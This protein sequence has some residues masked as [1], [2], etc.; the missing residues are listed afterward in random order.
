[1]VRNRQRKSSKGLFL[2]DDMK[3]AVEMVMNGSSVRRAAELKNVSYV[4]L[5]RY[6]KKRKECDEDGKENMKYAPNYTVRRVF[7]LEQEET[8]K[9]YL[10]MCSKIF[11]GLPVEDCRRVAYEMAVINKIACPISWGLKKIA[12]IDW[13]YGF[14]KRHPQLSQRTPEAC[15]LSRATSFTKANV[16]VFFNNLEILYQQ[17]PEFGDGTRVFNLDETATSTV[18][19]PQRI[20]AEK[21][22]KQVCK[23]T[24][25]EKGTN[26]TTVAI[27]SASG[28]TI[29][30][31]MIFPRVHFKDYMIQ[32]AP[33]GTLG[34]ATPSGWM[35]SELFVE[36]IKH[37]IRHTCSSGENPT[38]L[39]YDNVESHLSLEAVMLCKENGVSVLTLPPHSSN[40]M[41]PL[42]VA[43]FGP[44]K[45]YYNAALDSW[46]M[47]NPGKTASIYN[48][49]SFVNTAHQKSMTPSNII[50]GFKKSGIHP[51]DRDIFTEADFLCNYVTDRPTPTVVDDQPAKTNGYAVPSDLLNGSFPQVEEGAASLEEGADSLEGAA[52]NHTAIGVLDPG[53]G[54]SHAFQSPEDFRGYPK[55]GERKT[56][57]KQRKKGKSIIATSTPEMKAIAEKKNKLIPS[58]RVLSVKRKVFVN[59]LKPTKK[60][61][62]EQAPN[63]SSEDEEDDGDVEYADTDEDMDIDEEFFAVEPDHFAE[64]DRP[65]VLGD[66]VLIEFKLKS[67]SKFYVGQII[68]MKNYEGD[69]EVKFLRYRRCN[70][71]VEPVVNDISAVNDKDIKMLLEN[72]SLVRGTKRQKG[73]ISFKVDFSNL[74]IG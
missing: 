10:I 14:L 16:D 71:F 5:S 56:D 34:L 4:T 3:A 33:P 74:N 38:L 12:G 27:I 36:T 67:Q 32:G 13:F 45:T 58:S 37:F 59:Q 66:Y 23:A 47:Q 63:H 41:Q 6:V 42:D 70:T 20:V 19:K 43:V 68:Q 72:P 15:S 65:P 9:N 25:G 28:S 44:F 35:T 1:M 2:E 57:R 21:G 7:T 55:A 29:P 46:M 31:I 49:A 39:I 53:A 61:S 50:A 48:T 51:Y 40:K 26:V 54:P 30:P 64:L 69:Y 52:A 24:S 11:Y 18:Q 73:F 8:L 22:V 60:K 17:H 62:S